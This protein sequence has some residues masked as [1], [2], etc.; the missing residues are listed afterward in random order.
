MSNQDDNLPPEPGDSYL[1]DG[2]GPVD[3]TVKKFEEA[4]RPYA[5]KPRAAAPVSPSQRRVWLIPAAA[6]ILVAGMAWLGWPRKPLAPGP[7]PTW[8]IAD[9]TGSPTI[10]EPTVIKLDK[11]QTQRQ[12]VTDGVSSV[13]LSAG[14]ATK[15]TV[16]KSTTVDVV[17]G[18]NEWPWISLETGTLLVAAAA[19]DRPVLVGV[20][21]E[22]LKVQ[23]GTEVMVHSKGTQVEVRPRS[24]EIEIDWRGEKTRFISPSMCIIQSESGPGL[25]SLATK[26]KNVYEAL[27]N[28]EAVTFK[29]N[30]T[31]S[32][33]YALEQLLTATTNREAML[34]WNL[35]WRVNPDQRVMVR[36]R[37]AKLIV[38]PK[39]IKSDSILNLD[40]A[41]MDAWWD[42]AVKAA[43]VTG[44]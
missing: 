12:I 38:E 2:T 29:T 41:A 31:K 22:M 32:T 34:V 20:F 6:V 23:P 3:P 21:G 15:V 18:N 17:D 35:L 27:E 1:W 36:D 43:T 19:G 10:G 40:P 13:Q 42:A 5:F 16:E 4:L 9:T 28:Y 37:L 44:K 25:P 30:D 39:G 26:S 11:G 24:G 7:Q 14:T 8:A 33:S